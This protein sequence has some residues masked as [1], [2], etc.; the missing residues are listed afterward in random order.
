ML[1][2][3]MEI[4]YL[5]TYFLSLQTKKKVSY[6]FLYTKYYIIREHKASWIA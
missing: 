2:I 5:I 3:K 4:K 6:F 1:S